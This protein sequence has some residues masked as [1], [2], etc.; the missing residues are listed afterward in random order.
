MLRTLFIFSAIGTV[1]AQSDHWSVQPLQR[2]T[3]PAVRRAGWVRN[4]IDQ[5]ILARLEKEGISPSAEADRATLRRRLHLDLIGLPPQPSA[6]AM[7][8]EKELERL[9][10]SEHFGE[11]WAL[12][13]LDLAHYADSD[14]YRSDAFRPN[15]WRW[16]HWVIE[17]INRDLP[18][19]RFSIEQIAGDQLP[20]PNLVATGFFRN[21]LTNREGGT[22]PEQFR[23]EA[24][25]DRTA[26][27][28][29]AWLALTTNCAQCH[30][31][32]Y[33][34]IT[35]EDYFRLYAFFNGAEERTVDAPLP[36][37]LG[38][39]LEARS[40]YVAKREALLGRYGVP[41]R[42]DIWEKEIL[43]TAGEPGVRLDWDHAFDDLRT[44]LPGGEQIVRTTL[45]Q[46][47]RWQ[48]K[49]LTD[50]FIA[51][52][53]R[54]LPKEESER[55]GWEALTK[56]LR[57]LDK[58]LPPWSEALVLR[59]DAG[60]ASHLMERGDFRSP[61]RV[62]K[63]GTLSALPALGV[64]EPRRL[65]LARWL[66][67]RDHPLTA[68]VVV[69]RVWQQ[70]FG[71]GLVKT[72]ENF[73]TQ[74]ERPTHPELLDWLAVEFIDSGWQMKHLH[75]LIVSSATY[76]QASLGRTE[77]R[78]NALLARQNRVRL[79]A[80]WIRDSALFVAGLLDQSVGG[81]SVAGGHRR[82]MY[83]RKFRNKPAAF[84]TNFDAPPG[85]A[86]VCR[87]VVSN[88][89]LQALNLLNDPVFQ[90]AAVALARRLPDGD[91]ETRLRR[92]YGFVLARDASADEVRLMSETYE[93]RR[94]QLNEESAWALLASALLNT[95]EFLT[96]E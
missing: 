30:D 45:A 39:W 52:Y 28:S 77:D 16:R 71:R 88:T 56:Q 61:G 22:D 5:F 55:L 82:T 42:Q 40:V 96:R 86:P 85:Y 49:D 50:Y 58:E 8:F 63:P 1:L 2:P 38:A 33:D 25:M 20:R 53:N 31:H 9:L 62:V 94:G 29:T 69:N 72:S 11:K 92:L 60:R 75:R 3:P 83:L 15:A 17:A 91:F 4:P 44:A 84:L 34:P 65:D 64:A 90:E 73:G 35:Q 19:D 59:G 21:T 43:R 41:E 23:V 13:W 67:R 76:R 51:N 14:G 46:R 24:V 27:F 87:R 68:R 18:F 74:G 37:E 36:G 32:K 79:Q 81:R 80:E 70:Y 6:T 48:Q 57:A 89:P 66:F 10:A 54:V 7:P 47:D 93:R 95:D 12:P 78:E 26:T